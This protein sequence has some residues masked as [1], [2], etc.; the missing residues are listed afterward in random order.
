MRSSKLFLIVLV[1]SV[2]TLIV[3]EPA[4]A[5]IVNMTTGQTLFYDDFE[6]QADIATSHLAYPDPLAGQPLAAPNAASVGT[7]SIYEPSSWTNVQVTDHIGGTDPGA[8]QGTKYLRVARTIGTVAAAQQLFD[9][10]ETLGDHIRF[11]Q[12]VYISDSSAG[13]LQLVGRAAND[14]VRINLYALGGG[15]LASY[16]GGDFQAIS[17]IGYAVNQWQKWTI[18]YNIGASTFGLAIDSASVSGIGVTTG[19]SLRYFGF[20]QDNGLNPV[21]FDAAPVPEPNAM[22]IVL[23]AAVGLLAYAWR[24]RK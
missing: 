3:S 18:D 6:G 2:G 22:A 7:W 13:G 12:M 24:K 16:T 9:S 10:Q 20:T 1:F 17:G 11:Q 14:D 4:S 5:G 8:Y 15:S 21:Y 19:G 23:A